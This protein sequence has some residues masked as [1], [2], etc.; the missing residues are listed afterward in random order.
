MHAQRLFYR[1][2]GRGLMAFEPTPDV[3]VPVPAHRQW[4]ATIGSVGQPR[5]G[6]SEAG[7]ALFD[8]VSLQLTFIRVPYD[9]LAAAQAI[10]AAGLPAFNADRLARGR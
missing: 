5:D 1:G 4:L 9:H 3:A 2:A 10:L 7:Y 6:R 8:A